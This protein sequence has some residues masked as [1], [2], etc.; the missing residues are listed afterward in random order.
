MRSG[1]PSLHKRGETAKS[2]IREVFHVLVRAGR[3]GTG[4][5]IHLGEPDRGWD[6][7]DGAADAPCPQGHVYLSLGEPDAFGGLPVTYHRVGKL[8]TWG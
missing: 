5:P 7:G 4:V 8:V 3:P 2:P 1:F 6:R